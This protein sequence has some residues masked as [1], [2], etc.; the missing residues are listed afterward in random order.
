VARAKQT[1]IALGKITL[2]AWIAANFG[3]DAAALVLLLGKHIY[4]VYVDRS[5]KRIETFVSYIR[6]GLSEEESKTVLN[7]QFDQNDIC[8]IFIN[9]MMDEEN[10]KA[11]Y[12]AKLFR[13]LALNAGK[14]SQSKINSLVKQFK[15][16]ECFDFKTLEVLC[17][18]EEPNWKTRDIEQLQSYQRIISLGILSAASNG[19]IVKGDH[20]EF[21][22]LGTYQEILVTPTK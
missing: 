1:G 20:N 4:S 10:D 9:I 2:S 17:C 18:G 14:L 19:I 6:E 7:A 3:A 13:Y 16:L 8:N 5:K 11:L 15:T 12:Y 22:D 21:D